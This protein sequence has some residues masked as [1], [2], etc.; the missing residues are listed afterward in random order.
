MN[1]AEII[2]GAEK[3]ADIWTVDC[4]SVQMD[5]I[6]P[7]LRRLEDAVLSI[8]VHRAQLKVQIEL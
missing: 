1:E 8:A 7:S 3:N 5:L 2:V 4:V 6:D